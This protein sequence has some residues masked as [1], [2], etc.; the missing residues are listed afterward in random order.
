MMSVYTSRCFF[1][2]T[3]CGCF[4]IE[5]FFTQVGPLVSVYDGHGVKKKQTI[6]SYW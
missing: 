2:S 3:V 5:L 6:P 1:G 4:F